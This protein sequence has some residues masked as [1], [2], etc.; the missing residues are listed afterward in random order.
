MHM[1]LMQAVN[2]VS[3]GWGSELGA[4]PC[5]E[6]LASSPRLTL[7]QS[8]GENENPVMEENP[9][10]DALTDEGFEEE[11]MMLPMPL[12]M[13][14][15]ES[16]SGSLLGEASP[17]ARNFLQSQKSLV[18]IPQPSGSPLS[19]A[20]FPAQRLSSVPSPTPSPTP[21]HSAVTKPPQVPKNTSSTTSM[22]S[23]PVI[24]KLDFSKLQSQPTG[25]VSRIG[26]KIM[27]EPS[28]EKSLRNQMS[29]D[30]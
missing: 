16:V 30:S 1:L 8:S 6:S 12:P 17:Q 22:S 19:R 29:P 15:R 14:S 24:P 18:A 23:L 25:D 26:I 4:T 5:D 21:V 10:A 28:D 7:Q 3:S 20:T 11:E 9:S 2:R 27:H 13:P